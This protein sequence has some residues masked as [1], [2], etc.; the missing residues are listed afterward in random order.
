MWNF[1]TSYSLLLIIGAFLALVSA[2]TD[3]YGYH[4]F[5][6]TPLW[7]NDWVA[8]PY[9][10]WLK[11]YGEGAKELIAEPTRRVLSLH[12]LV[13]DVLMA[14]F[15]AIAGKE[16]W[17]AIALREGSLRGR[18]ALTPLIAT[19]GGMLGPISVYLGIAAPMRSTNFDAVANGC[20]I[21]TATDI[22]FQYLVGRMIF[23][24]VHFV[25]GYC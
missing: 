8:A 21:P 23:G 17:E 10:Y 13:N 16:V 19:S 7:A 24:A 11:A 6:E 2:N 22:A 9:E 12:Y 14:F 3:P 15:F 18:K 1:V 20:A 4:H 25:A 5:V